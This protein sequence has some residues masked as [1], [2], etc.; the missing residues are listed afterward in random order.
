MDAVPS[1]LVKDVYS[2][3]KKMQ[4]PESTVD[5]LQSTAISLFLKNE[6]KWYEHR[7][8]HVV[9]DPRDYVSSAINW[10][11]QRLRRLFLH[12]CVPFWQPNPVVC[13]NVSILKR[14]KM[15]K[16]EY[17]SW[18]WNFKNSLFAKL[19][20]NKDNYY[21]VRMEDLVD[22]QKGNQHFRKLFEFLKLPN[23]KRD[24]DHLLNRK[25][26]VSTRKAF[27]NWIS[28]NSKQVKTLDGYC[29][30]LMRKYGYGN[31]ENW[32]EKLREG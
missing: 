23:R 15:N 28:W 18:I 19:F 4:T 29:G 2:L 1:H 22:S 20:E 13:G 21:M 25:V 24:W 9:R 11:N 7:I 10:K 32:I 16:F 3:L 31:E 6:K 17:F 8:V 14:M 30:E 27:T 26:N 5:P 12:H